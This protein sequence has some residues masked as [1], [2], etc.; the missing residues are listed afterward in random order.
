MCE[1]HAYQKYNDK[2]Y[3]AIGFGGGIPLQE[4]SKIY[5][6][7]SLCVRLNFIGIWLKASLN[8]NVWNFCAYRE[9]VK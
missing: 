2:L 1:V 3:D 8:N 6:I 7:V 4:D 9:T 5:Y